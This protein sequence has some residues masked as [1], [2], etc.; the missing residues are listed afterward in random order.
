M[1][2]AAIR[3]WILALSKV[4][5]ERLQLYRHRNEDKYFGKMEGDKG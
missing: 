2:L 3:G 4:S 1:W 5:W